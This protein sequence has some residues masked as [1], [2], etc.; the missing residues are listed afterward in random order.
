MSTAGLLFGLANIFLAFG[1]YLIVGNW[2][3]RIDSE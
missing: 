1:V 3:A 2:A